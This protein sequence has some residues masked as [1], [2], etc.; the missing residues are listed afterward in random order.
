MRAQD[1]RPRRLEGRLPDEPS[2]L[3]ALQR[4]ARLLL[5][6]T[7]MSCAERSQAAAPAVSPPQA[8]PAPGTTMRRDPAREVAAARAVAFARAQL[9]RPYC[10]GGTG[11]TCF[12]CSGL[13]VASWRAGGKALP[14]T[15]DEQA[16]ALPEVPL[17]AVA[18][19]D[20]VWRRGHVGIYVGDGIV[21]NATKPGDVVRA[22][23]L[24]GYVRALR[25]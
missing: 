24:S 13:T 20:V 9:G 19:G 11:P 10:R 6:A 22:Q 1:L 25:P 2:P 14:R 3:V 21:V 16:A 5:V 8:L 17:P 12:D 4:G 23:P 18:P 7:L 15:A